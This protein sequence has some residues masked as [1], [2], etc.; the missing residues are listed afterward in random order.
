MLPRPLGQAG[1][2]W[3]RVQPRPAGSSGRE[4]AVKI[5]AARRYDMRARPVS[6][7]TSVGARPPGARRSVRNT[8]PTVRADSSR[9]IALVRRPAHRDL[10]G[11]QTA[12]ANAVLGVVQSATAIA[13]PALAGLL[14]ALSSPAVVITLDAASYGVSV[15]ALSMLRVPSVKRRA[16]WP[17]RDFAEAWQ[18]FSAQT[19][20]WL[21][22]LQYALFN[23]PTWTP[24]L[25][26]GP[27]VARQYLG[28]A[29]VW[30]VITAAF[31]CGS[32][33]AGLALV[34]RRPGRPM[35][36]A[37]IGTFGYPVPCLLL[38]IHAPVYAIAAGALLADA[39]RTI[40]TL[41]QLV[42]PRRG[43]CASGVPTPFISYRRRRDRP[44][45]LDCHNASLSH[46]IGSATLIG[47]TGPR[48]RSWCVAGSWF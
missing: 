46:S 40:R 42:T 23:L 21:T 1:R 25:L 4:L 16:Q 12:R 28:G 39:S 7:Q 3:W 10:G 45:C 9:P 5:S 13:G 2:S 34:R 44:D 24:Y 36:V 14:I 11:R 26:L 33:L 18:V 31:A 48:I 27:I 47:R 19:W 32:V 22:T 37:V 17:W 29:S 43:A 38:A 20:L 41:S 30:G 35:A 6:G 15:V 8:G